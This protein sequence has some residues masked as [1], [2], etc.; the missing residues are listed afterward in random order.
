MLNKKEKEIYARQV[1][2][3]MEENNLRFIKNNQRIRKQL[4]MNHIVL[5]CVLQYLNQNG[6]LEP[7]NDKVYQVSHNLKG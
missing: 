6:F 3:F 2:C 5:A 4:K 7:W 1:K